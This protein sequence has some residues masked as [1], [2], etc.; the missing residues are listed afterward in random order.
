MA[1][2]IRIKHNCLDK[3]LPLTLVYN[4]SSREFPEI[5]I[6][7]TNEFQ[8]VSLESWGLTPDEMDTSK[9]EIKEKEVPDRYAIYTIRGVY[10]QP[11]S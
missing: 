5:P 11:E 2:K 7:M 10:I 3:R 4:D 1:Y 9:I 6:N 8:T